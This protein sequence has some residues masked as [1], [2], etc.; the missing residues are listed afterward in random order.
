MPSCH[1]RRSIC[2]QISLLIL[3]SVCSLF[4]QQWWH[5]FFSLNNSCNEVVIKIGHIDAT[6]VMVI[7]FT[8]GHV[9]CSRRLFQ[10]RVIS[11]QKRTTGWEHKMIQERKTAHLTEDCQK[12]DERSSCV[13]AYEETEGPRLFVPV[14]ALS[15]LVDAKSLSAV[16]N[17]Y[18]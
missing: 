10:K 9:V 4:A 3:L 5:I 16:K 1:K 14:H 11:K 6:S 8:G 18:G 12:K 15:F 2:F 13:Y 7:V 17:H